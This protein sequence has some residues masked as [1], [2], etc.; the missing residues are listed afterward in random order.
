MNKL[1]DIELYV[2]RAIEHSHKPKGYLK[3]WTPKHAAR[4]ILALFFDEGCTCERGADLDHW[5]RCE[6]HGKLRGK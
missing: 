6:V 4:Q 2:L 5:S 1:D 3:E